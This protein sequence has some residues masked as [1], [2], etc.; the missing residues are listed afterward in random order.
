MPSH[1]LIQAARD[2]VESA[3]P[4]DPHNSHY[5][6]AI[7]TAYYALFHCLAE[8]SANLLA[9]EDPANRSRRAWQQT[10]RALNHGAVR[11]RSNRREFKTEFPQD[12][13]DFAEV[14]A[15]MLAK[16][17]SADYAP[18]RSPS[19]VDAQNAIGDAEDAINNFMSIESG[20]RRNF[21]LYLLLPIR[22]D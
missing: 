16:R 21:A 22:A 15:E 6:R 5:R 13:Q 17:N 4:D 12:I 11:N 8:S 1:D 18:T 14:F 10:Y 19:K 7:S 2:L 9:G 20:E 3:N